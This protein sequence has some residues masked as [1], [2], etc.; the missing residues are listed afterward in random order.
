MSKRVFILL[1][2]ERGALNASFMLAK[3]LVEKGFEVI[4]LTNSVFSPHV[5]AQGF[6]T[7]LFDL[8]PFYQDLK[9]RANWTRDQGSWF[10][11]KLQ[12]FKIFLKRNHLLEEYLEQNLQHVLTVSTTLLLL[13]PIMMNC[14]IPFIKRKIPIVHLNTTF[15]YRSNSTCI[16]VFSKRFPSRNDGVYPRLIVSLTWALLRIRIIFKDLRWHLKHGLVPTRTVNT[17]RKRIQKYGKRVVWGEYGYRLDCEELILAPRE[18]DFNRI[19]D[20]SARCYI[21][22]SILV[23]RDDGESFI[24]TS[25]LPLLYCSLGTYGHFC[26]HQEFLFRTVVEMM[27]SLP[28]WMA[29]I[30]MKIDLS[31]INIDIPVNVIVKSHVPQLAI[32]QQASVAITHVGCSSFK[33]C[34]MTGT[35]I[36][37]VPWNNDGFGNST[38]VLYHSL[39]SRL[40][41]AKVSPEI[42]KRNLVHVTTDVQIQTAVKSM[43]KVFLEQANCGKGVEFIGDLVLRNNLK[44]AS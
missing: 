10:L 43:K 25:N 40:N 14:S 29:V 36:I 34:I 27:R 22:S 7:E 23:E 5:I 21:G 15:A 11:A 24:N 39:G 30:Q 42:L 3:G 33:E 37:A 9:A 28:G 41:I 26:Q 19:A 20:E 2:P 6:E 44:E 18:M 13:D 38:R 16:P 35:P 32:L 12:Y 1:F 4:Y 17:A 31:K 8:D